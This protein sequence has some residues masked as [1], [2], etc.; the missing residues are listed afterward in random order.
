[1]FKHISVALVAVAL[2]ASA[3]WAQTLKIVKDRGHL[4]CGVNEGLPGFSA[5]DDKGQ[6][7]GIDVDLCRAIA[8]AIFNDAGK[9]Q[10]VPLST[11]DR[12]AALKSKKVDVLSRNSTWTMERDTSLDVIFAAVNYYDGQGFMIRRALNIDTALE[13]DG[14]AIC[15]QAGT[16]TE[17]NLADYF[18]NNRLTHTV[19]ML[20]NADEALKAYDGG[21]CQVLTSDVSQLH[22]Q[23][24]RLGNPS[25]HV[26][27]P[28]IISK[29]PLGPA[30]RQ[31]DVQWF[32]IVKWTDFAMLNAEELNISL[33]T[34]N[35]AMRSQ[36]PD[37]RRL[38][39]LEGKFGEQL[40]LTNDWAARIVRL[41]GNYGE[42]FERNVGTHFKLA[43]PRGLN[44]LWTNGGIQYAP[45]IR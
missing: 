5:P 1:M 45:P 6:W 27:L 23:R 37:V 40:G 25:E 3:S 19:V 28:E 35:E 17:L 38:L 32:N 10:F 31:D 8:A 18:R 44:S 22:A 33:A 29:E 42:V 24:S 41:V 11:A 21:R 30:V 13:L 14:K 43:I 12:F 7:S 15:T 34:L 36:K 9:V 39:G 4:I 16:T 2:T 20:P 26:I